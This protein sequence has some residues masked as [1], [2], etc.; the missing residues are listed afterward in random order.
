MR[1]LALKTTTATLL[2]ALLAEQA[3]AMMGGAGVVLAEGG[4]SLQRDTAMVDTLYEVTVMGD[5][6]RLAPV[7]EAINQS[8]GRDQGPQMQTLGDVLNKVAPQ[9]MDYVLHPF[10]FA[11]RKKKKKKKRVK[12]VLEEFDRAGETDPFVLKLDSIMRMEGLK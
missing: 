3:G 12:Q 11:E 10:G 8:L 5:S 7:R 1:S 2:L 4:D 6:L 9:A